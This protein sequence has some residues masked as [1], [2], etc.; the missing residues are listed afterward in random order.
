[1]R[2]YSSLMPPDYDCLICNTPVFEHFN[3]IVIKVD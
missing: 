2:L 3:L 1:M